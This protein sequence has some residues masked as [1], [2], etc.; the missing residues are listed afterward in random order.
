MSLR[1]IILV[2]LGV[3]EHKQSIFDDVLPGKM[4]CLSTL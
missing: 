3:D 1:A 4:F 2:R